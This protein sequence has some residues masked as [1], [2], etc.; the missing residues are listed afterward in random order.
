M[1]LSGILASLIGLGEAQGIITDQPA[2]EGVIFNQAGETHQISYLDREFNDDDVNVECTSTS[3]CIKMS[4]QFLIDEEITTKFDGVHL[5]DCDQG[6]RNEDDQF[7][8]LCTDLGYNTCG[9]EMHMNSTH[10]SYLNRLFTTNREGSTIEKGSVVL[11]SIN[12]FIVPWHCVYPLDYLVGL[13]SDSGDDYGF[14]IPQIYDVVKV[15]LL[16][17]PGEGKGDF[18]VTMMLYTDSSYQEVYNE[19]PTLNV[20]DR[21]YVQTQL[22]KGPE[23]SVIQTKECWA[24]ASADIE[25]VTRY[26][27]IQ[28]F[29]VEEEAG[30]R[31][32][33][34]L[35][36]NGISDTSRWESNVFKFVDEP[37]V[38]L[39]CRVRICFTTDGNTCDQ[40]DCATRR[41]RR[42]A[43]L[44]EEEDAIVSIGP[45][46]LGKKT[47]LV[48][49]Q[50]MDIEDIEIFE[51]LEIVETSTYIPKY[52]IYIV[53]GCL[54]VVVSLISAIMILVYKK[55]KANAKARLYEGQSNSAFST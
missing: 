22:L 55:K 29:C 5:K 32:E 1:R 34:D 54:V 21:L 3:M 41:K 44:P 14:F 26:Q 9:T 4:K 15:T 39:H 10:V 25:D 38:H 33:V 42:E 31:A 8:E 30:R 52:F 11:S 40:F 19:P 24:T 23:D 16:M 6:V 46:K 35:I 36:S 50:A 49:G 12:E 18:P 13:S 48:D 45:L 7:I 43:G 27:L 47:L 51:E 17:Q 28:D 2:D 53:V 20:T 37:N